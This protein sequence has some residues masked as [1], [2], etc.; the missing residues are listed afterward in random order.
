MKT[1]VEVK[2]RVSKYFAFNAG[3]LR[4][5]LTTILVYGLIISFSFN[6][7]EL[8]I[9]V[10]FGYLLPSM[11]LAAL[12]ILVHVAVV[13]ILSLK[14]GYRAEF[15]MNFYALAATLVISVVSR[16]QLFFI[17]PGIT[18]FH[19]LEGLRIGRYRYGINWWEVRWPVFWAAIANILVALMFRLISNIGVFSAN[20]LIEKMILV[21]LS[22]A[23]F[24]MLPLPDFE[25]L[26][27]FFSSA[28]V[29]AFTF[30][31]VIGA[32]I[33]I[34]LN[35]GFWLSLIVPLIIGA[36]GWLIYLL[37]VEMK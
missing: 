12:A 11:L 29:Y 37:G 3:E 23:F 21:N 30:S 8:S 6:L 24:A 32:C 1:T 31:V 5:L 27:I 36:A 14:R 33:A 25:G 2:D 18:V 17:V 13:R 4:A 15:R 16:G 28:I 35:I 22:V 9:L 10:W 19:M 26:Y 7:P 20:P 34:F